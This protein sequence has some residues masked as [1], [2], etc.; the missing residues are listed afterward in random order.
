MIIAIIRLLRPRHWIKN[1]FLF[2]S[3]IFGGE[4]FKVAAF[5]EVFLGF[6]IFSLLSSAIYIINDLFD[7]K[8]DRL[9]PYKRFRPLASGKVPVPVAILL[10]VIIM[11][12]SLFAGYFIT[13]GFFAV[14]IVYVILQVAYSSLLK[15]IA[16]IDI[17]AL[18]SG[19]L[20]RVYAGEFITGHNLSVWLLLTIIS[21]SLFLAVGKRRSELTL[22][23]SYSAQKIANTR[24]TLSHYNEALLDIYA[25]LFA[26]STFI[27]YA[28]F[29]FFETPVSFHT[30][31][32]NYILPAI[33]PTVLYKKW[34][35]VTI[36]P[37]IYGLMR[38]L[39]IMYE[40]HQG[41]SPER[42]LFTD[43]PLLVTV[44]I[45]GLLVILILYYIGPL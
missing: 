11:L 2:P 15:H 30:G 42:V 36:V 41:E 40:K 16:I 43:I 1:I 35:M 25:T 29:T 21:L 19:Y 31:S 9:H 23:A 5:R 14:L 13:P 12:S 26:S 27:S 20:L 18:A 44:S 10:S 24:K 7:I 34:L 22:I 28:L 4:L 33:I 17:L 32:F 38:Y 6:I 45:W 39:Q 37:V 3:I 8:K